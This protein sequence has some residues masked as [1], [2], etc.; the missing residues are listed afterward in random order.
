MFSEKFHVLK[1]T[2]GCVCVFV[3]ILGIAF[4]S[5][6]ILAFFNNFKVLF[7]GISLRFRGLGL[8]I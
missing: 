4:E 5:D 6:D 1:E 2:L 3:H 8:C 7:L